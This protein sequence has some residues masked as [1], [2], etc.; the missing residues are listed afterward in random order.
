MED[1]AGA[2]SLRRARSTIRSL[3]PLRGTVAGRAAVG[4]HVEDQQGFL[5]VGTGDGLVRYD[6]DR[7]RPLERPTSDA[8]RRSLGW[9]S[10]M[11]AETW[12]AFAQEAGPPHAD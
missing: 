7:F 5:W 2:F 6:G 9:V 10:V 8:T 1:L 4:D 12:Q 11:P 3:A